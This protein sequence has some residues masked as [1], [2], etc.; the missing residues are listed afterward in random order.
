[1]G[2]NWTSALFKP[3]PYTS[4]ILIS[5]FPIA[6]HQ[7]ELL[8][9]LNKWWGLWHFF[10]LNHRSTMSVCMCWHS[11]HSLVNA[12]NQYTQ[13]WSWVNLYFCPWKLYNQSR[14]CLYHHLA[15]IFGNKNMKWPASPGQGLDVR[16][17]FD[18]PEMGSSCRF[19]NI[20]DWKAVGTCNIPRT[21]PWKQNAILDLFMDY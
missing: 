18:I 17:Q 8:D 3:S 2:E 14:K 19:S 21:C 20:L 16:G 11:G 12:H 5:T 7:V 15:Y 13:N 4:G 9:Y 10:S 1:M 6:F